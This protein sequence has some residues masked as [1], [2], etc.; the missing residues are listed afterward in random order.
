[1]QNIREMLKPSNYIKIFLLL[2]V[3]S[4][5]TEKISDPLAYIKLF[6]EAGKGLMEEKNIG[7]LNFSLLY[8]PQAYM[9]LKENREF[10]ANTEKVKELIHNYDG[11]QYYT[12]RVKVNNQSL[13]KDV[14]SYNAAGAA[15]YQERVKYFAFD[16]QKDIKLVSGGD[17]LPCV[18]FHFERNF[19]I[20][21]FSNFLLSFP[22]SKN[23]NEDRVFVYE[24][25]VL[26]TGLVKLTVKAEDINQL[27]NFN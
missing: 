19:G 12:L 8:K 7:D 26:G 16:M 18:L 15:D 17:T 21:D 14:L 9:A 2:F 6:D 10:A 13:G 5:A 4:C 11:F 20:T 3:F 25:K 27:P 23:V 1:M 24:D 22:Q